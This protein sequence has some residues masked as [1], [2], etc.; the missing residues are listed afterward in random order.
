[1]SPIKT[2]IKNLSDE[3]L[4]L[5]WATSYAIPIAAHG[6]I[7]VDGEPWSAKEKKKRENVIA[8]ASTG[9]FE[10]SLLITSTNGE[11]VEVPYCPQFAADAP[12]PP[13][14]VAA[15]RLSALSVSG[16]AINPA[17]GAETFNYTAT[18]GA[19]TG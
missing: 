1:M 7:I 6:E 2:R 12:L 9:T 4:T 13:P 15:P 11:S 18:V 10:L 5:Y 16:A 3:P 8:A 17:F 19:D 14:V